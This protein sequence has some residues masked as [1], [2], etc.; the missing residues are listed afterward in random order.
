MPIQLEHKV[1]DNYLKVDITGIRTPGSE[2]QEMIEIWSRI[3]KLCE[4]SNCSKILAIMKI[5]G[6]L[7]IESAYKIGKATDDYVWNRSYKLAVVAPE[8]ALFM[9]IQLSET[10]WVN[11]GYEAKLFSSIGKARKWLLSENVVN[12]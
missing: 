5:F 11:M 6:R 12:Y 1:F 2:G 10:I 9:N 7:P 8:E 3:A 4:K